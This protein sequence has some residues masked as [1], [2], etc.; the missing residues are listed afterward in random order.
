MPDSK[1]ERE[2]EENEAVNLKPNRSE[3]AVTL[4][5]SSPAKKAKLTTK[6]GKLVFGRS[7]ASDSSVV[8]KEPDQP[9]SDAEALARSR[10]HAT[11]TKVERET[12]PSDWFE[13][14]KDE[15]EKPYFLKVRRSSIWK[16]NFHYS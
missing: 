7:E 8:A 6:N 16:L 11:L 3:K 2:E 14:F 5:V 1:R 9:K 10:L 4:S 15:I 12:L 13:A